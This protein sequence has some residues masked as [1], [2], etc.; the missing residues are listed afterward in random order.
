[1]PFSHY[2]CHVV[3]FILPLSNERLSTAWRDRLNDVTSS[4]QV[5]RDRDLKLLT[6]HEYAENLRAI[7]NIQQAARLE[8]FEAGTSQLASPRS[9]VPPPLPES[10]STAAEKAIEVGKAWSSRW[11]AWA[12]RWDIRG[13]GRGDP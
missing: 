13:D 3:D 10:L 5:V 6:W 9:E 11:E 7:Y 1:M 2:R 4:D 8:L 12:A